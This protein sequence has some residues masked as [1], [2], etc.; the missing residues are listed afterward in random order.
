MTIVA[1]LLYPGFTALDAV[2]PYE[3]LARL[4][5]TRVVFVGRQAGAVVAD[6][7]ALTMVAERAMDELREPDVVVIPGGLQGSFAAAADAG[8]V[9]WVRTAHVTSTWTTSVCTGALMLGA[10]GILRGQT[11]T[12]HWAAKDYLARYGAT[13]V[14]ERVV[15]NDRVM[16]AA[17]VSAG[18]DMGLRLAAHLAGPALAGAVQL[19]IEY[20]PQ[21]PYAAGSLGTASPQT[22]RL[23]VDLMRT[24]TLP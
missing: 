5:D 7:G 1:V 14:S 16:T 2:G 13:Y 11:A 4:P 18:I 9:D 12:T 15:E 3:V 6:T 23:A 24:E 8:Y 20:D 19:S 10:A 22:V 21:P 17:G